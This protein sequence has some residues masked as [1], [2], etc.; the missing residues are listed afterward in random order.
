M[1]FLR[2][3]DDEVREVDLGLRGKRGQL[4]AAEGCP[5][6]PVLFDGDVDLDLWELE[7]VLPRDELRE[8]P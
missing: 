6:R 7:R 5:R 1:R 4:A 8:P 2:A 3:G